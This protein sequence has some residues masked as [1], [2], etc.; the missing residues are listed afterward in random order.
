MLFR[1]SNRLYSFVGAVFIILNYIRNSLLGYRTPRTFSNKEYE[2]AIDYDFRIV[3]RWSDYLRVCSDEN[4]AIK[5]KV[6]LELGPGPDLG[7]GFILSALGVKKYIALDVNGL[8]A[9]TPK[10]FYERLLERIKEKYPHSDIAYLKEQ[11]T[12]YYEGEESVVN[13]IVNRDFEI[14]KAIKDKVDIIFSHAAFEHFENIEKT[15]KELSDITKKGSILIARIDLQTHARW[16]RDKD[17]LNIYRYNELFW[18]TF[19]F[20]G[21]PNR[22]RRSEYERLLEKNNWHCIRIEPTKI[23]EKEYVEKVKP[24]LSNTFREFS[25]SEMQTLGF[26]IMARKQ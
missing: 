17:P 3:E 8:A 11:I 20:N 15:I 14:K 19:K 18:S 2:R 12:K 25:C 16:I 24:T 7:T 22:I 10:Y 5:N 9:Y 21:S 13:Y 4:N 23:L 26:A 1:S 6:V